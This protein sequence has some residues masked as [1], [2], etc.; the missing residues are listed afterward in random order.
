VDG[1]IG[2]LASRLTIQGPIKKEKASFMISGRRTYVDIIS[3]PF[4]NSNGI[5]GLPYYF[6]DLNGKFTWKV[7]P[8]NKLMLSGYYGSDDM[9]LTLFDGRFI[10]HT[11]WGNETI[12]A[13]WTHIYNEKLVQNVSLIHNKFGFTS[14]ADFDNFSTEISSAISDYTAK[15][16]YDYTPWEKHRFRFGGTYT[17]HTYTPR[18]T[19]AQTGSVNFDNN[20]AND[21]KYAH[22]VAFY[23]SDDIEVNKRLSLSL[24][25]RYNFF[26]QTGPY[27]YIY[28]T[29]NGIDTINYHKGQTVQKYG[30]LEP[31][32]GLRYKL[33]ENSSFKTALNVN[34]QYIHLVSLTNNSMPFDIWLPAS[35]QIKPQRGWQY[36]LGY[37]RNLKDNKY[38]FSVEAYYKEMYNQLEYR[39]NYVP[40]ISGE[41]EEDLV[42]GKGWSRGLEFFLKKKYG[43]LQGWVGYTLSKTDR[44]FSQINQGRIFPARYDRRH[45]LNIVATYDIN[46]RWTI[47]STFVFASGQAITLP[48]RRYIVGGVIYFQYGDRNSYRMQPYN[49][50]DIAITLKNKETKKFKSSITLSVYNVYNRK[51]PYI[52]YTDA[53]GNPLNSDFSVKAKKIYLFPVMPSLT[54]NFSF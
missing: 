32:I 29:G 24:G 42:S 25:L 6:Y 21:H 30:G 41:V 52:Y 10:L 40:Q 49:R 54:W 36:S 7:N 3:R 26:I 17:W 44:K 5:K 39:Q 9:K 16:D 48:E 4:I 34:N 20:T 46:K 2:L 47:G 51:N 43:N 22:D 12:T 8:K 50:L 33:T 15:V 28:D 53:S 14:S 38:E 13:R 37:F 35:K 1:G 18:R 45:D 31:R 11:F 23:I 27:N 19:N